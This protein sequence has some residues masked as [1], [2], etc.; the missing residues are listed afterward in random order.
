MRAKKL[1]NEEWDNIASFEAKRAQLGYALFYIQRSLGVDHFDRG[2]KLLRGIN[3]DIKNWVE[4]PVP[5]REDALRK[6][7]KAE[8]KDL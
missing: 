3:K 4:L 1:T 8:L 6:Y 5:V 7:I 2:L